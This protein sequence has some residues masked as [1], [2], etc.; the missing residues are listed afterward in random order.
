MKNIFLPTGK[1]VLSLTIAAMIIVSTVIVGWDNKSSFTDMETVVSESIAEVDDNAINNKSVKSPASAGAA[2]KDDET[3]EVSAHNNEDSTENVGSEVSASV[4]SET[5]ADEGNNDVVELTTTNETTANIENVGNAVEPKSLTNDTVDSTTYDLITDNE[6]GERI[7]NLPNGTQKFVPERSEAS[8]P[9]V[10]TGLKRVYFYNRQWWENVYVHMYG[11]SATATTWPGTNDS[12]II[13]KSLEYPDTYY[14]DVNS[15]EY[16]NLI[17]NPGPTKYNPIGDKT[18]AQTQAISVSEASSSIA[19]YCDYRDKESTIS[20]ADIYDDDFNSEPY[21]LVAHNSAEW[22]MVTVYFWGSNCHASIGPGHPMTSI[23]ASKVVYYILRNTDADLNGSSGNHYNQFSL[24]FNCNNKNWPSDNYTQTYKYSDDNGKLYWVNGNS[25]MGKTGTYYMLFSNAGQDRPNNLTRYVPITVGI[26]NHAVVAYADLNVSTLNLAPNNNYYFALSSSTS[27]NDV[28]CTTDN[29]ASSSPSVDSIGIGLY[30]YGQNNNIDGDK[31]WY[32]GCFKYTSDSVTNIRIIL[33]NLMF[34]G[35][36]Y[37]IDS[38]VAAVSDDKVTVYAKNGTIR[39]TLIKNSIKEYDKFSRMGKTRIYN[40]TGTTE[41]GND[42]NS[43]NVE[44]NPLLQTANLKKGTKIKISTTISS[45]FDS[46]YKVQA[47]VVNGDT[48]DVDEAVENGDGTTTYSFYYQ[49]PVSWADSVQFTENK[50]IEITPVYFY[51]SGE[52]INFYVDGFNDTVK[53]NW[54]DGLAAYVWYN[55]DSSKDYYAYDNASKPAFGGYPGQPMLYDGARYY[56]QVPKK[57]ADNSSVQGVTLNNYIWDDIHALTLGYKTQEQQKNDNWQTYD[58]D[59][60]VALQTEKKADT[61]VARFQYRE[62][63]DNLGNSTSNGTHTY[64]SSIASSY[65]S[66]SNGWN[67]LTDLNNKPVDIFDDLILNTS[68]DTVSKVEALADN[69]KVHVVSDGYANIYYGEYATLWY[70]Y[71][72]DGSYITNIPSSALLYTVKNNNVL[73]SNTP[74][75]DFLSATYYAKITNDARN[76]YWRAYRTLYNNADVRNTPAVITYEE[77]MLGGNNYANRSDVRWYY[78][79]IYTITASIKIQYDADGDGEYETNEFDNIPEGSNQG[80]TTK[81]NAYFNSSKEAYDKKTFASDYSS[82]TEKFNFQ[83]DQKSFYLNGDLYMFD[84]WY[85]QDQTDNTVYYPVNSGNKAKNLT[86]SYT[87][88][89]DSVFVARYKKVSNESL[90]VKHDLLKNDTSASKPTVHDGDATP[91]VSVSILAPD[92]TEYE[93]LSDSSDP[94]ELTAET[95]AFYKDLNDAI[96]SDNSSANQYKLK[97]TLIDTGK[98]GNKVDGIYRKVNDSLYYKSGI[99]GFNEESTIT[100]DTLKDTITSTPTNDGTATTTTNTIYTINLSSL[101]SGNSLI[102]GQ[103]TYLSNLIASDVGNVQINFNY[104]DRN[105]TDGIDASISPS[106]KTITQDVKIKANQTVTDAITSMLGETGGVMDC[107]DNVVDQYYFW[108]TQALAEKNI[109]TQADYR[110]DVTGNTNY[111]TSL[112]DNDSVNYQYHTNQYGLIVGDSYEVGSTTKKNT[113]NSDSDKWVTYYT[114]LDSTTPIAYGDGKT[115]ADEDSVAEATTVVKKVIVWA[116]NTP[117]RYDINVTAVKTS[118]GV[119]YNATEDLTDF[120]ELD[121]NY[122][123]VYYLSAE[124]ADADGDIAVQTG[125]Y[126]QRLGI[127]DSIATNN[128][129]S[130]YLTNYGISSSYLNREIKSAPAA[131][132]TISNKTKKVVFDGWYIL[133][134]DE[135]EKVLSITKVSSDKSYGYRITTELDLVAGYKETAATNDVGVSVTNN[136]VDYYLE[137]HTGVKRVRLNTQLNVYGKK[138]IDSDPKITQTAAIYI[139]LDQNTTI[140]EDVINAVKNQLKDT[141][142]SGNFTTSGSVVVNGKVYR[143]DRAVGKETTLSSK[144]RVQFVM[145]LKAAS[146]NGGAFSKMLV[147]GGIYY[148]DGTGWVYSDNCAVYDGS[149]TFTAPSLAALNTESEENSIRSV[150]IDVTDEVIVM[151]SLDD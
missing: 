129:A 140:T 7:I 14:V 60:F 95:L 93:I 96:L 8:D 30:G 98:Y 146:Y 100:A 78:S 51:K 77:N 132:A 43:R 21:A 89:N 102:T 144:N 101:Y 131:K 39:H 90:I 65:S 46:L 6:N 59:D 35:K 107:I 13:K 19:Y 99:S 112:K 105:E 122:D 63:N 127:K 38:A 27:Y 137:D 18:M 141:F 75:K 130:D 40:S 124:S 110:R 32:Y 73:S 1:S 150:E 25:Q 11:G 54:K 83:A 55:T 22:S 88:L 135:D 26:V 5:L 28:I 148:N 91:T 138:V 72:K 134:K 66:F 119:D 12:T 80:D 74:P 113:G 87:M 120:V 20:L 136:G 109:K 149:K 104:Y 50:A 23:S 2:G 81:V 48:Y 44:N 62:S 84:G 47:F 86:G 116:Y 69:A 70:I 49:I 52:Y 126:N 123:D 10:A 125:F 94:V 143:Y 67:A 133:N 42:T 31:R 92:G 15:T 61:I 111:Q 108:P 121:Q 58:Y 145:P 37:Y 64:E 36:S 56:T 17:F 3:S 139:Q 45:S 151:P 114:E 16:A 33:G 24:K 147:F 53:S 85:V 29:G 118:S 4:A 115:Y 57:I 82:S 117:K 71:G 68:A 97:I 34:D 79:Q 103:L 142:T 128:N 76:T 41:I 9:T 106:V